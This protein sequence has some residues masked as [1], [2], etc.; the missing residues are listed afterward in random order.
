MHQN[1]ALCDPDDEASLA[2]AKIAHIGSR[3]KW[4]KFTTIWA[5]N[6]TTLLHYVAPVK[7][8]CCSIAAP[9]FFYFSLFLLFCSDVAHIYCT[10][11]THML[12]PCY[13]YV[14]VTAMLLPCCSYCY[15]MLLLCCSN[16]ALILFQCCSNVAPMLLQCYSMLLQ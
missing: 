8:L 7:L 4:F 5:A 16:V 3:E 13:F 9:V 10:N 15:L 11:I 1:A 14:F 2:T 6:V 12:C